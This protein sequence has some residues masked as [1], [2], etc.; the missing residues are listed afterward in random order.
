VFHASFNI[1]VCS[2]GCGVTGVFFTIFVLAYDDCCR[3]VSC[4]IC[5]VPVCRRNHYCVVVTCCLCCHAIN[6][7]TVVVAVR[8]LTANAIKD[9]RPVAVGIGV[10]AVV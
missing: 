1:R 6:Q 4:D 5:F 10:V 8:I 7:S 9:C 3:K 2:R